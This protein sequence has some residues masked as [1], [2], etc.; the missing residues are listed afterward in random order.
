MSSRI[1]L[2]ATKT[3]QKDRAVTDTQAEMV[4]G[5]AAKLR[6]GP[7]WWGAL[8]LAAAL[9]PPA[10]ITRQVIT[11]VPDAEKGYAFM[12]G[13]ASSG[14]RR[15]STGSLPGFDAKGDIF[16][17][18]ISLQQL[19]ELT[20]GLAEDEATID[21]KTR[22][23]AIG[24][25]SRKDDR[26]ED[27]KLMQYSKDFAAF[28]ALRHL[29]Y[30]VKVSGGGVAIR[31]IYCVTVAADKACAARAP[32]DKV[33]KVNDV[34]VSVEGIDTPT[35]VE[36]AASLKGRTAKESVTVS[37]QRTGQSGLIDVEVDL[38]DVEGRAILGIVPNSA[39]PDTIRFDLPEGVGI[40]SGD[41][42]GPSAGLA[43]T[44]SI[45]DRLT[46]GEL[47]G[48]VRVAVTGTISL[49]NTVGEIGGLRQKT[50]AVKRSGAKVFLVPESQKA[51]AEKEAAGSDLR[52]I[53]V[54]TLDDALAA[55][56]DIG[57]NAR[58]LGLPGAANGG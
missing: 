40:E 15:V 29:G 12:P 53:G 14:E 55:L 31:E 42:G 18:T 8:A 51:E 37:V 5:S 34:I 13:D 50:V 58:N 24:D 23:E 6:R 17:V 1:A 4:S 46:P 45:L 7:R 43:F 20:Q 47:T 56:A 9:V 54:R 30:P 11:F 33:L 36:L 41:V 2:I 57:G 3:D 25:K 27:L 35:S 44:L 28:V 49:A 52:V 16:F 19:N 22:K 48:G 21:L 32:A 38:V 26:K 10:W 39:P